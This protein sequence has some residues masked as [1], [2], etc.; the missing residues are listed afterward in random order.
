MTE[1]NSEDDATGWVEPSLHPPAARNPG[2]RVR[3]SSGTPWEPVVGYSRTVRTGNLVFVSGTTSTGTDG[4]LVGKG[5]P[6]AQAVQIF[7]NI[8]LALAGVGAEMKH[9][10]RSR[11]FLTDI[12]HWEQVAKAHGE[13]F[14]DI[15][16]VTSL[17]AVSG[18]IHPDML[19]EIEVDAVID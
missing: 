14:V 1:H 8:Q 9:V 3:Y 18:F 12:L 4:L 13:V 6:Y 2:G 10:V 11:M 15:R 7:S 17:L 5:D 16:P 19:V